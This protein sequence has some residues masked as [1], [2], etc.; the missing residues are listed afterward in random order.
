MRDVV[1][2]VRA[3]MPAAWR[4]AA[5]WRSSA[6]DNASRGSGRISTKTTTIARRRK[7]E[8]S[9]FMSVAAPRLDAS[10]EVGTNQHRRIG[11]TAGPVVPLI[12]GHGRAAR[13][14]WVIAGYKPVL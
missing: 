7:H 5:G 3:G 8:R 9:L 11:T 2:G 1:Q 14:H 12:L 4:F 13:N 6:L 10:H